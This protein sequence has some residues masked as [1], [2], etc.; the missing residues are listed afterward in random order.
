MKTRALY[1]LISIVTILSLLAAC[2]PSAQTGGASTGGG[3]GTL[4]VGRGGDSVLLD[5]AAA[6]DGESWRVAGEVTEP[7][8][9]LD[10][11][12]SKVIPWLA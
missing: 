1:L 6:T 5:A 4:I 10:G 9:R 8:V 3:G 11:T 12:S 2:S 7:L